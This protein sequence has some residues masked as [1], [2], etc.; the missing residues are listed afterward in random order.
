[1]INRQNLTRFALPLLALGLLAGCSDE[2]VAPAAPDNGGQAAEG[3]VLDG[4]ISDAMLPLDTLQSQSPSA[5]TSDEDNGADA[6]ANYNA[7]DNENDAAPAES[8]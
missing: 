7:N 3:D 8:E 6:N 4:S 2:A 1:M 5:A